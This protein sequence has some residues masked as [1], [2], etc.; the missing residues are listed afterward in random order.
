MTLKNPF[1]K[2]LR[3]EN[4]DLRKKLSESERKVEQLNLKLEKK[5]E[6]TEGLWKEIIKLKRWVRKTNQQNHGEEE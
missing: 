3:Q 1:C 2:K 4:A 6:E 5:R